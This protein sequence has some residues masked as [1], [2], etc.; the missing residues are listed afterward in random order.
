[1][2]PQETLVEELVEKGETKVWPTLYIA[3]GGTGMEIAQRVRRRILNNVWGGAANP[4]RIASLAEFPLA[5]FINFDLDAGSVTASDQ[6][7]ATDPLSDLV[8]FTDSEKLIFKL[9]MEKY[10]RTDGE[11]SRYPHIASWFPLSRKK[12]LDLKI[13][14]TKGAGQIRAL[15]RLYFFDKYVDLRALL[16]DKTRHL[17]Q[18]AS[19][20]ARG[21]LD[22]LGLELEPASLRVVV[23]ASTAGGTGSG[24]F[25]DMG[26]LAKYIASRELKGAKVDLMLMLPSG[27]ANHGKARTEANT[28]AALMELESCMSGGIQYV[29]GGW[30]GKE[31]L[32]LPSRPYDE[33]YLFDTGNLALEKTDR[34]EDVFDMVADILFED[35]TSQEFANRKRSIAVNQ[36]QYKIDPL[37]VPVDPTKYGEMKLSYMKIYSTFGQAII[38][39]QIEQQRDEIACRH[40]NDM[41]RV[42]FGVSGEGGTSRSVP[43]PTPDDARVIL[44]THAYCEPETFTLE[45]QFASP[46]IRGYEKGSQQQTIKLIDELLHDGDKSMLAPLYDRIR[47]DIANIIATHE[48]DQ[49]H[50]LVEKL[51]TEIDRDLGIEDGAADPGAGGLVN[52][53]KARAAQVLGA[54]VAEQSSLNQALWAALD[55]REKGGIDYT[56]QLID[57]IKDI[58]D[59]DKTGL[60]HGLEASRKWFEGLCNF[61][62]DKEINTLRDHLQ[63]TIGGRF[64]FGGNKE[65]HADAK[66]QQIGDAIRWYV[67]ARLRAVACAHGITLLGKLSKKLG[68]HVGI[69][70]KTSRKRW[71][72]DSFAG[73]IASLEKLI[74]GI[75]ADTNQEVLR[76]REA[77]KHAHAAYQVI[78]ASTTELDAARNLDSK[79]AM[80]WALTVFENKGGSQV[81]YKELSDEKSR[82]S[83]IRQLRGI[84]LQK[85]PAIG[86]GELNPLFSA[87]EN[88]TD[89]R[90][91]EV[92]EQSLKMAMPWT[93][94]DLGGDWTVDP[95]QYACVIGIS[96]KDIFRRK[97]EAEFRRMV[98]ARA[99]LMSGKPEFCEIG[100][101]GKLTC[102]VELSGVPLTALTSLSKW[103]DS[104]EDQDIKIPTHTHKD[105]TLFQ[106]P[107]APSVKRLDRQAEH[108]KLYLQGI[109][110]GALTPRAG[111]QVYC[112]KVMGENLSIGSES[113][114]RQE[115]VFADH[116]G[117]IR[118]RITELL[119]RITTPLQWAGLAVLYEYCERQVYPPR[120][121][122]RRGEKGTKPVETLAFGFCNVLSKKLYEEA[123]QSLCRKSKHAG[124]NADELIELMK[125][126]LDKYTL[127]ITGSE[128]DVNTQEVSEAHTTKR[129]VIPDFF[130]TQWLERQCRNRIKS[131]DYQPPKLDKSVLLS[132]WWVG[133]DGKKAGPY[134]QD[135]L[136]NLVS[137]S[138]LTTDT[139]VWKKSVTPNWVLAGDV[140]ELASLFDQPPPLD[141]EPPDF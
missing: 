137:Q 81:L 96:G 65:A 18:G 3:L 14:P 89:S 125:T 46:K 19:I 23:I 104:Y 87:L 91:Q 13:D 139:K 92:F 121:V 37:D 111:E 134:G 97:F 16:E 61:L 21:K 26:Y 95:D 78:P 140:V 99:R 7:E 108:F 83:L 22:R 133:L 11:L 86:T 56:L 103:R 88:L 38:D 59:N 75:L 112:I 114:I 113:N 70:V 33:I 27:Y 52:K 77:V 90:R 109:V 15:A 42:F 58:I 82:R 102:Y 43:P 48:K 5:Q 130:D 66:I 126:Q 64:G 57:R 50:P 123:Y 67:E 119:N 85:L 28:Y 122:I 94:A 141:D 2:A 72:G 118:E 60:T 135:A 132:G 110:L 120:K 74:I 24:A 68:E 6:S 136:E 93:E 17:L 44:R 49:R 29:D 131:L 79:Q 20:D 62:R 31:S 40:I 106:H 47:S 36:Q 4:A 73:K 51:K 124:E 117:H 116:L 69:D 80:E 10:L 1:M 54:L 30:N 63:Q 128:K 76:T 100:L 115:G 9:D 45:Y 105:K 138:I 34:T 55:N 53:I 98:P 107:L 32:E 71:S 127:E 25:L 12:V 35:F 129:M 39:T 101:A 8:V 41:L 84:A